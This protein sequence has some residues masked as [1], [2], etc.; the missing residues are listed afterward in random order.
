MA[1]GMSHMDTEVLLHDLHQ[2]MPISLH[3]FV[4]NHD[5]HCLQG[6]SEHQGVNCASILPYDAV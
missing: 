5:R 4:L 6:G 3:S 1:S 2:L